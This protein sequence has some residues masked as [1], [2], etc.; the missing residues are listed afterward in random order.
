MMLERRDMIVP[1]AIAVSVACALS[2]EALTFGHI[3]PPESLHPVA[4]A[5]RRCTFVLN[6]NPVAWELVRHDAATLAHMLKYDSVHGRFKG[7]LESVGDSLV[8]DGK[9][10]MIISGR[11]RAKLPWGDSGAYVG[12]AST[13]LF[14]TQ[15]KES[16]GKE[17]GDSA[18]D[19]SCRS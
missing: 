4:E 14:A 18:R 7:S 17:N 19:A 2:F 11:S 13:G 1:R 9:E 15:W 12:V 6:L 3:I 10:I 8:G 16:P 5:Y